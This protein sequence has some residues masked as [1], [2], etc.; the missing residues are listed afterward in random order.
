MRLLARFPEV[1]ARAARE[2]EPHHLATYLIEI[3]SA[4]NSW[5]GQVQILDQGK[6]EPHKVAIVEALSHTLK[7][8]L[9][10]LAIPAPERM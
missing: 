4:F 7:N 2:Y 8:G 9:T 5:Y 10:I 1:V 3:A 6:D